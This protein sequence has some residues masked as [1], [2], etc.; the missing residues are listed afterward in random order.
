MKKI[1]VSDYDGTF[2]IN[3]DDIKNNIKKVKEF[4]NKNNIFVIATGRSYYDFEKK[5]DKYPF[6]YDYLI[7]NHGATRNKKK[8]IKRL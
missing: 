2:Y 8:N 5:L 1:L 3:E 6:K 7:L 4:R